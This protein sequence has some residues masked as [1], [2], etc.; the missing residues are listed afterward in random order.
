MVIKRSRRLAR[1][2]SF[3]NNMYSIRERER[4]RERVRRIFLWL[5]DAYRERN[6]S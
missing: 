3:V 1:Y 6:E 5:V 4:E 2:V